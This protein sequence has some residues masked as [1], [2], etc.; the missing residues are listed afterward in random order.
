MA[1]LGAVVG[2]HHLVGGF[3][4][5]ELV[6]QV[7]GLLHT[8]YGSHQATYD[9]RR[10]RRKALIAKVPHTRRYQ[11]TALGRRVAILFTKTYGRVIAPGLSA[12]DPH[13]PADVAARI[14]LAVAWRRF[15]QAF[16]EFTHAN[17]AAA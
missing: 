9:L 6:D 8:R 12:L 17:L 16:E 1:V 15:E 4:N 7:Q 3:S 14:P 13:I 11:L 2:F 5:A 10:L